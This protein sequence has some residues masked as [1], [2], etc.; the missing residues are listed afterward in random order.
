L[1]H[2]DGSILSCGTTRLRVRL[3]AKLLAGFELRVRYERSKFG[4]KSGF[5]CVADNPDAIQL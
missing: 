2:G 5:S 1:L 3:S 4:G